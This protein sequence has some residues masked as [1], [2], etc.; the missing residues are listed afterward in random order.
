V[1]FVSVEFPIF[2]TIVFTLYHLVV[3]IG[4]QN[5]IILVA[6]YVFYGFWDWRFLFLLLGISLAN[7]YAAILIARTDDPSRRKTIQGSLTWRRWW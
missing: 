4:L 6:S 5:L 7:Y 3:S 1:S 2:L